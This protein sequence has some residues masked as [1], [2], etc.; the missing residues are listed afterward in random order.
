MPLFRP[1]AANHGVIGG[2]SLAADHTVTL[3]SDIIP[4]ILALISAAGN[5]SDLIT[6]YSVPG[7]EK[8]IYYF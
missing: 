6:Y 7:S 2:I 3:P 8:Q 1:D 5:C 4:T